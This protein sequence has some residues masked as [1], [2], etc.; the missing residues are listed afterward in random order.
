MDTIIFNFN[1]TFEGTRF[2][3][4][5]EVVAVNAQPRA[6][7]DWDAMGYF[8][9]ESVAVNEVVLEGD[10]ATTLG[11]TDKEIE[12]QFDAYVAT[13]QEEFDC[14]EHSFAGC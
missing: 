7:S 9:V 3:V 5:A 2:D 14:D 13:R 8:S 11:L 12:R 6:D 10:F 1:H 4:E